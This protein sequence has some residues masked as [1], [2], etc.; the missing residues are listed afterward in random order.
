[1][2]YDLGNREWDIPEL[3]R[4]LS[5]VL[6]GDEFFEDFEVE[7]EFETIGSRIVLLNARR[8]DHLQLILLAMEDVTERRRAEQERE[9]LIGEL[10]HRVKNLFA[11]IRALATQ[12]D[13]DRSAEE[14]QRV[15]LGRMRSRAPTTCCSRATGAALACARSPA[16]CSPSRGAVQKRSRATASRCS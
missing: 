1:M 5:E 9:L 3:R 7:H 2:I 4:L 11:V 14:Y 10:N 13:G 15:L 6:P 12:G 16:R 8:V